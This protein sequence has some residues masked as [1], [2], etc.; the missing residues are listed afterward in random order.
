MRILFFNSGKNFKCHK[1]V[2]PITFSDVWIGLIT[3]M[4]F[5]VNW[6]KNRNVLFILL[7][8]FF[9]SIAITSAKAQNGARADV[10]VLF[11]NVENLFNP[12][13]HPEKND[14]E[15]TPKGLR[16]WD[17]YRVG[18]KQNNI[19]RVLLSSGKWNPPVLAGICEVEDRKVLEGLIWNTGL[20][21]LTYA[22]EHFE[23]PDKRGI[24]VAL[25]YRQDRFHVLTSRPVAVALDKNHRPTRDILYVCGLLDQLDTLH[26]IVNHWPSRWGGEMNTRHKRLN[27]AQR[28]KTLCDSIFSINKNAR[29]IAMGDFN[30]EP[31]DTSLSMISDSVAAGNTGKL[32]NMGFFAEGPVS[33]T[34]KHRFEWAVFDQIL[35]SGSLLQNNNTQ[36]MVVCKPE[37]HIMALPFLL[38]KD[39]DFPGR[40]IKRTYIGY[41][42]HGG[43]SDHLPVMIRLKEKK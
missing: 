38:E 12:E 23:S 15:F 5:S 14:D 29:I 36:G 13:D 28:L 42:Y 21:N 17:Y 18:E 16:H 34:I 9:L 6:Y 39:P 30:D 7:Y 33:G 35:V 40:R 19:A 11:Y 1:C 8:S 20:N 4:P 37:L 3:A 41:K 25:L 43:Y 24:D 27:A 10:N 32:V 22:F 31:G 2:A 26:V